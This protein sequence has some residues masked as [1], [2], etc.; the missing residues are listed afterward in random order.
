MKKLFLFL[1]LIACFSL[2]AQNR[3]STEN[4]IREAIIKPGQRITASDIQN[5]FNRVI[6]YADSIKTK[7][8]TDLKAKT[9]TELRALSTS[10]LTTRYT[11]T[12]IDGGTWQYDPSDTATSDNTGTVLVTGAGKRLKRVFSGPVN[13]EWFGAVGDGT[14]NNYAAITAAMNASRNLFFPSDKNFFVSQKIVLANN[15]VIWAGGV[16]TTISSNL[17][18]VV[19]LGNCENVV[20]QNIAFTSSLSNNVTDYWGLVYSDKKVLKNITFRNCSFTVPNALQNALKFVL[21]QVGSSLDGLMVD[22]CTFTN[23]GRMGVEV[24]NHLFD[25]VTRYRNVTVQNCRFT[26]LGLVANGSE[27]YGMA[28][29]L[30]G[31]GERNLIANNVIDNPYDIGIE[32]GGGGGS[33]T[34]TGN[35][36]LNITRTNAEN[37]TNLFIISITPALTEAYITGV[38]ISNNVCTSNTSVA[39]LRLYYLYQASV[40]NN[41]FNLAQ[42]VDARNINTSKFVGNTFLSRSAYSFYMQSTNSF[43][44]ASFN[45]FENNEF[46]ILTATGQVCV[47]VCDNFSYNNVFVG[48][49]MNRAGTSNVLLNFGT[50]FNNRAENVTVSGLTTPAMVTAVSMTNATLTLEEWQAQTGVISLTGSLS[51]GQ[52]VYVPLT[53][54]RLTI[55]N[56]TG[57]AL[58][59]RLRGQSTTGVTLANGAT[60]TY[61]VDTASSSTSWVVL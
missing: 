8:S 36:F 38:E 1:F 47:V 15:N 60:A 2:S 49:R 42:Q 52:I 55:R 51:S 10:D 59:I 56:S 16:N 35:I 17:R 34:I 3:T 46:D 43:K 27:H 19:E 21:D 22:Q 32:L 58:E 26:N 4:A 20:I 7:A 13:V 30:A 12:S 53:N 6:A 48:G 37:S 24:Q 61:I 41:N 31:L 11:Y 54:R 28:V 9:L 40:R 14:T 23:I 50:A 29:S 18:N 33:T 25:G 39:A 57:Q 5:S 45:Y 44:P